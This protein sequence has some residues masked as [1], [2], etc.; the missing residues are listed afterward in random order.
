MSAFVRKNLLVATAAFT[1]ADGSNT[2]PSSA[3]LVVNY[4]N[5]S[6]VPTQAQVSMTFNSTTDDWIGTWDTSVVKS[7]NVDWMVFGVGSLQAAAEGSFQINAN[8][9]NTV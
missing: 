6:G 3:T 7:G 1:A 4:N 2:Q 5:I 8:K 9:A